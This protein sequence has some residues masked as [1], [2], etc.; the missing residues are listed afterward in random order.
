MSL[1]GGG[2]E[3][4]C[5]SAS[6]LGKSWK[7][8]RADVENQRNSFLDRCRERGLWGRRVGVGRARASREE[9]M[10]GLSLA[11]AFPA[12]SSKSLRVPGL[13]WS[14]RVF[15]RV[16]P[17]AQIKPTVCFSLVL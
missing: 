12:H 15:T 14:W 4:S 10:V 2:R 17:Q 9:A 7:G 11:P 5:F 13:I 16:G 8:P 6:I 1:E 3:D